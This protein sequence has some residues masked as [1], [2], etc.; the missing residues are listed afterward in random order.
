MLDIEEALIR[1]FVSPRKQERYLG[2]V[3]NSKRRNKF[4]DE[5]FDPKSGAIS[6]LR[7]FG[8]HAEFL[9]AR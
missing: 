5:L 1:A 2:F 3:A 6:T 8:G 4:V 7:R 9:R